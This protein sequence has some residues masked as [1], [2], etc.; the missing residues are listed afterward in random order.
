[1]PGLTRDRRGRRAG[2]NKT[3]LA[4]NPRRRALSGRVGRV[5]RTMPGNCLYSQHLTRSRNRST[6]DCFFLQSSS[7]Y[8]YAPAYRNRRKDQDATPNPQNQSS[9]HQTLISPHRKKTLTQ[10]NK[11]LHFQKLN[12]EFSQNKG[13]R[14]KTKHPRRGSTHT[15]CCARRERSRQAR[16]KPAASILRGKKQQSAA[17]KALC[18]NL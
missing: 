8:L 7:T 2:E 13:K 15:H 9:E 3:C 4:L 10:A 5:M 12:V 6:S 14:T 11:T 1:M 16:A 18:P 17:R